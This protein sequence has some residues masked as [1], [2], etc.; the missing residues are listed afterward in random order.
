MP[1]PE[2]TVVTSAT[3]RAWPLPEPGADKEARGRIL[4]VGGSSQNP[5][6]VILAAE[7]ALRSGA[8]KLQVATV[9]DLAP[10]VATVLPEALVQGL[11]RRP[12][13]DLAAEAAD[14]ILELA[15]GCS[16][17]LLGPGLQGPEAAVTLLE[18]VVPHLDTTVVID[19]LAMA[20]V[21]RHGDGLTHLGGRVVLTPNM[22]EL[23]HTL[24]VESE[25]IEDEAAEGALRLAKSADAVVVCGG[26][27]TWVAA[28]DDQL[29]QVQSG[30]RGLAVSGSG[31]VQ[32]GIVVGLCARGASPAQAGTWG[33][34]LHGRAGDRLAARVG[35]LGYLARE[36]PAEIPLILMEIEA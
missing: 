22:Q 1:S 5:G 19:A 9:A 23:A 6:A 12:D 16:A 11:P 15:E 17:I 13:G 35:R 18:A 33:A 36:L 25:Q 2:P 28:P 21:T 7:A 29:W 4:V 27:E 24:Q 26:E 3:L 30:N 31:D 32:A 20:F 34:H 14:M 8:G 10:H